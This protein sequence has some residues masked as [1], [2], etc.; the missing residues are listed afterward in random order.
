[1]WCCA[2]SSEFPDSGGWVDEAERGQRS[3]APVCGRSSTVPCSNACSLANKEAQRG[4]AVGSLNAGQ[5]EYCPVASDILAEEALKAANFLC[6]KGPFESNLPIDMRVNF[7][8]EAL[9]QTEYGSSF[10]SN[11]HT[12]P[13]LSPH[14]PV[15]P[16]T[17][18][19]PHHGTPSPNGYPQQGYSKAFSTVDVVPLEMAL[20]AAE[21]CAQ[22]PLRE[23]QTAHASNDPVALAQKQQDRGLSS[24]SASSCFQDRV[25]YCHIN[26]T[27]PTTC[28]AV[29]TVAGE[30]FQWTDHA[31]CPGANSESLQ[32]ASWNTT[33]RKRRASRKKEAIA[34]S[35]AADTNLLSATAALPASALLPAAPSDLLPTPQSCPDLLVKDNGQFIERPCRGKQRGCTKTVRVCA[36]LLQWMSQQKR[37]RKFQLLATCE[38]CRR[39]HRVKKF[40]KLAVAQ[41]ALPHSHPKRPASQTAKMQKNHV[42]SY[43]VPALP[44]YS[45]ISQLAGACATPAKCATGG[46]GI[47]AETVDDSLLPDIACA[48]DQPP[49]GCCYDSLLISETNCF[50]AAKVTN[51]RRNAACSSESFVD[52]LSTNEMPGFD[53]TVQFGNSVASHQMFETL[54]KT[55]VARSELRAELEKAFSSKRTRGGLSTRAPEQITELQQLINT[56]NSQEN[57]YANDNSPSPNECYQEELDYIMTQST[58]VDANCRPTP[59]CGNGQQEVLL[60]VADASTQQHLHHSHC[61]EIPDPGQQPPQLRVW[62]EGTTTT[63]LPEQNAKP[64][65]YTMGDGICHSGP[66]SATSS[67]TRTGSFLGLPGAEFFKLNNGLD[68]SISTLNCNAMGTPSRINIHFYLHD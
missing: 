12:L 23:E 54:H 7:E 6:E 14:V 37:P 1:M 49:P 56:H 31:F 17:A 63:A 3:L 25:Y 2:G 39:I 60:P 46:T 11:V 13:N 62:I 64:H 27:G 30:E 48:D 15:V 52:N 18:L 10:P 22:R 32:V 42:Q 66:V 58:G 35:S 24:S 19:I 16:A 36:A 28:A 34:H 29:T 61:W 55:Q 59:L 21:N 57:L 53:D 20:S 5:S 43:P 9:P 68:V 50:E 8:I 51:S 44:L 40:E 4:S 67:T 33:R 41:N 65:G 38:N 45:E 47:V 26:A